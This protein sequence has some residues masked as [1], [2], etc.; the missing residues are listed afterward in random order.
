MYA[1]QAQRGGGEGEAEGDAVTDELKQ[2]LKRDAASQRRKIMRQWQPDEDCPWII[3][4]VWPVDRKGRRGRVEALPWQHTDG[5][6]LVGLSLEHVVVNAGGAFRVSIVAGGIGTQSELTSRY[7]VVLLTPD[8]AE[9]LAE[10][11]KMAAD[12]VKLEV[13]DAECRSGKF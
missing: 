3:P 7:H 10:A 11:L 6:R 9:T 5:S 13:P 8:E 12:Y 2:L 4:D 1:N